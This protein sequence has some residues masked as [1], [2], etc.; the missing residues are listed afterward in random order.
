MACVLPIAA[1][2]RRIEHAGRLW[3]PSYNGHWP[4]ASQ[5][6]PPVSRVANGMADYIFNYWRRSPHEPGLLV[7][8]HQ[9]REVAGH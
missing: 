8:A 9:M 6:D 3:L 2:A 4:H 5:D 1:Q 7:A